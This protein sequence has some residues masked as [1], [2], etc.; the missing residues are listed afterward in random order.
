MPM[1]VEHG[2]KKNIFYKKLLI[3]IDLINTLI[4]IAQN[5]I[6]LR[7]FKYLIRKYVK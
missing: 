6:I 1:T 3:I 4:L 2:K 7:F 5:Y